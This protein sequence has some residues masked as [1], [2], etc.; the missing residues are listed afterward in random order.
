MGESSIGKNNENGKRCE[1]REKGIKGSRI[2]DLK[3][4]IDWHP[5][6][7]TH[8]LNEFQQI[9]QETFQLFIL[10]ASVVVLQSGERVFCV[11][12]CAFGLWFHVM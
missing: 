3:R 6:S 11:F 8:L 7:K 1:M 2:I 5:N 4:P 12:V 10:D 9:L